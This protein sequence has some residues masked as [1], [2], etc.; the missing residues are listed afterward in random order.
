MWLILRPSLAALNAPTNS[1]FAI[2]AFFAVK[3]LRLYRLACCTGLARL[4][5]T[6]MIRFV[7]L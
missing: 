2:F 6:R 1:K 3:S 5:V 7:L 4:I